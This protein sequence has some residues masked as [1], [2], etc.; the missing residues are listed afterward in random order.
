MTATRTLDAA[1]ERASEC[2]RALRKRID[3]GD[4]CV[5]IVGLGYVGL[6]LAFAL[7]EGGLSVVGVDVDPNKVIALENGESYLRHFPADH[8]AALHQ[9]SRFQATVDFDRLS[10]ADVIV[11]CV[12]TPLGSHREPDLSYVTD[13]GRSIGARARPGQ[14]LVL[15][16]TTYP[17]TTRD[18]FLPAVLAS[19]TGQESLALGDNFF[20]A[21]S[22]EREDPGRKDH[23]T[24]SIPKLV[25][26]L[27]APSTRVAAALYRRGVEHVIEVSSAEVAESAKILENVFRSVN[28]ALVNEMK[29][30]LHAMEI[31]IWEV[32]DAAAT[33][34]FGFMPFY[35]GPGLG[36]HCIPIDPFYLSWKAKEV[37]HTTRF[38]ELAGEINAAMPEYVVGRVAS[39]LND[40]A[41]AVRGAKILVLGLAYKPDVD[42]TRESPAFEVIE[43]LLDLGADVAY[44]DPYVPKTPIKRDY[45]LQL[46]SEALTADNLA[47]TDVVLIAT[48]HSAV[49]YDLIAAHAPL[50]V[51]TRNAMKASVEVLRGRWVKA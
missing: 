25:G 15:E 42:D 19:Y 10:D 6:P 8:L 2:E 31:D 39:A 16:S 50:I 18:E 24:Q 21:Y 13:T 5:A 29:T 7:H 49:D 22:P 9:S 44:H 1:V 3:D 4:A 27:D 37:Q 17:R 26:G 12:P 20:V 51:D 47:R 48:N 23:N 28:I 36:G 14:L 33:K 43:R 35:P 32:V 46:S 45:D 30:I 34:P 38:I 41:K 40:E 11:V